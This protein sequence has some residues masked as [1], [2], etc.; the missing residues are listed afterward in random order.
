MSVPRY[1]EEQ[2]NVQEAAPASFLAGRVWQLSELELLE[3]SSIPA[4]LLWIKYPLGSKGETEEFYKAIH[5]NSATRKRFGD[6]RSPEAILD[7]HNAMPAAE[8]KARLA[9]G[10]QMLR[11]ELTTRKWMDLQYLRPF[12]DNWRINQVGLCTLITKPMRVEVQPG[13]VEVCWLYE[14]EE[15][16]SVTSTRIATMY[17]NNPVFMFLFEKSGRLLHANQRALDHYCGACQDSEVSACTKTI[18][19][20][21][22]FQHG[23]VAGGE[24]ERERAYDEAMDAIFNQKVKAH[25]HMQAYVS[26]KTGKTKWQELEMWPVLDRVTNSDAMLVTVFNMTQRKVLEAQL[27]E[28]QI[29]LQ[30]QN[31]ELEKLNEMISVEKLHLEQ[32]NTALAKNLAAVVQEKLNPEV[33]FNLNT[34]IDETL[35]VLRSLIMGEKPPIARLLSLHSLLTG[36]TTELRQPI[37]LEQQ[38][39]D[40]QGADSEVAASMVQLLQAGAASRR[41]VSATDGLDGHSQVVRRLPERT[42]PS[43][44]RNSLPAAI[45]PAVERMLQDAEHNWHFDIF[46]F[47]DATEGHTLSVMTFYLMKR[48]GAMTKFGMHEA[49][50]CNYLQSLESG[51]NPLPYHN[52]IH[53]ASVV[54]LTHMLMTHGGIM[55]AKVVDDLTLLASLMAA[56]V[57]DYGHGGVNNDFLNRTM[58]DLAIT[59]H[60]QSPWE[61]HHLA[62]SLRLLLRPEHCFFANL[63]RE[64]T[65]LWR[66]TLA[67][68]VLGTDMKKHFSILTMFLA[69]TKCPL[70]GNNAKLQKVGTVG[71]DWLDIKPEN[72]VLACQMMLKCA[73]IG[74][75]AA[76]GA[77]HKRWAY[78]LEEEMFRQGDK[79]K[80]L[81]LSVSP[82]M[83]RSQK[84]GITRSQVGFFQIVGLPLFKAMADVFEDTRPLYEG[85]MANCQAWQD[86]VA[87]DDALVASASAPTGNRSDAA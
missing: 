59:Y 40:S 63:T 8:R 34:P 25:R 51:Y 21:T 13:Q 4:L 2:A 31:K 55:R 60:F 17:H 37:N 87:A 20:R 79:E 15:L 46:S 52:A 64:Q 81:G 47:A 69:A 11:K 48:A 66:C 61:N 16:L 58:H 5:V 22:L 12:Y 39:L 78:Q 83:D 73:D 42:G 77:T 68:E 72:K 53:V 32:E 74:H 19:L 54:Q 10:Q 27:Q 26:H 7:V 56:T 65:E 82:L 29:V 35:S 57:H 6:F 84:G 76:D 62:A 14:M 70:P 23:A 41:V 24:G 43:L 36:C 86:A 28:Q 33:Q 38:L 75:L 9:S 44:Q 50:L 71:A 85:A 1:P 67:D 18:T 80:A 30:K 49:S 45:T 3:E